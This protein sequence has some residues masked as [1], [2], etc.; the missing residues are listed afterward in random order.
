MI[1]INIAGSMDHR[2]RR[3][4]LNSLL[5]HSKRGRKSVISVSR[6]ASARALHISR[7]GC[8]HAAKKPSNARGR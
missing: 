8:R 2:D 6:C 5:K 7:G 1:L 3:G 4:Q